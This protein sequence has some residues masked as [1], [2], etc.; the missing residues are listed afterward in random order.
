ML[1]ILKVT[2]S[3]E[4]FV[5]MLTQKALDEVIKKFGIDKRN[6]KGIAKLKEKLRGV[7]EE[8]YNLI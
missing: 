3:H 1:K 6:V 5:D 8:L 7:A 2:I 4:A